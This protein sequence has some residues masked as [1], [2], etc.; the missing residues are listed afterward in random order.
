[1]LSWKVFLINGL[2][3]PVIYDADNDNYRL[4]SGDDVIMQSAR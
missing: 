3:T 2:H 4:V 1:M